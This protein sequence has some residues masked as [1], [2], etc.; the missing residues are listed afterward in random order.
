M[1]PILTNILLGLSILYMVRLILAS[2]HPSLDLI[3]Y[4]KAECKNEE[5][6]RTILRDLDARILAISN[7]VL[8]LSQVMSVYVNSGVD[9]AAQS[10]DT[11]GMLM[12]KYGLGGKKSGSGNENN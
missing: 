11:I 1:T 3:R 10:K 4:I 8:L 5:A 6:T 12:D 2:S 7:A 9:N